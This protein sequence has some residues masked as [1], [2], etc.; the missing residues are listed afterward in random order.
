MSGSKDHTAEEELEFIHDGKKVLNNL[1]KMLTKLA[2]RYHIKLKKDLPTYNSENFTRIHHGITPEKIVAKGEKKVIIKKLKIEEEEKKVI[3]KVVPKEEKKKKIDFK[4]SKNHP[5]PS[6]VVYDL[7]FRWKKI[8]ILRKDGSRYDTVLTYKDKKFSK[9]YQLEKFL[10]KNPEISYD[11][12]LTNTNLPP[13][14]KKT[15]NER[16]NK[17]SDYAGES[18]KLRGS[19][20]ISQNASKEDEILKKIRQ[21]K[22]DDL[23]LRIVHIPGKNRGVVTTK[24]IYRFVSKST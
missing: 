3:T 12:W 1:N 8:C 21:M 24:K 14:L 15:R 11:K 6:E 2:R 22:E 10:E 17:N 23:N 4:E 19:R 18:N 16:K 9:N 5:R 20:R 7:P 13:D